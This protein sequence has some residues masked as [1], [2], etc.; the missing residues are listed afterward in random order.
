MLLRVRTNSER[1]FELSKSFS[2]FRVGIWPFGNES[3]GKEAVALLPKGG[4][5]KA[6]GRWARLALPVG[7]GRP[8]LLVLSWSCP[9]LALALSPLSS[10]LRTTSDCLRSTCPDVP[11]ACAD[12]PTKSPLL[13]NRLEPTLSTLVLL[14]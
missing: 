13:M 2:T 5:W 12:F 11:G 3:F 4:S 6:L 7:L 1:S 10:V 8:G 14:S 9:P